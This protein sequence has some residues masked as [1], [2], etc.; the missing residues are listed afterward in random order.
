MD[1]MDWSID[2]RGTG[3][4]LNSVK[5]GRCGAAIGGARNSQQRA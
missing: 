3:N 5:N 1:K 4:G 2:I